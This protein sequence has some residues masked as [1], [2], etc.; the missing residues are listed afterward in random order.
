MQQARCHTAKQEQIIADLDRG[1]HEAT[2]AFCLRPFATY[3]TISSRTVTVFS[4][5]NSG[6]AA[7]VG[8]LFHFKQPDDVAY[9]HFSDVSDHADDVRSPG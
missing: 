9:W 7:S 5:N 1:G 8:A 2:V 4:K 3:K 6:K